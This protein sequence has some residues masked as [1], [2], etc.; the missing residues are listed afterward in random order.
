M[1]GYEAGAIPG[2]SSLGYLGGTG[3]V[4]VL[5]GPLREEDEEAAATSEDPAR[6]VSLGLGGYEL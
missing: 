6:S 5:R 1:V 2:P 4:E 3:G